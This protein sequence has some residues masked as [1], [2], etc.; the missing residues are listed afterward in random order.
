MKR[1][2]F[3]AALSLTCTAA[4]AELPSPLFCRTVEMCQAD[5][6]CAPMRHQPPFILSHTGGEGLMR[7]SARGAEAWA[8]VAPSAEVALANAPLGSLIALINAG[9][10]EEGEIAL[11]EHRLE[12]A[13]LSARY[14]RHMCETN[15]D[16]TS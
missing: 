15:E 3:T 8:V 10:T 1:L 7:R 11:H 12:P 4:Y 16:G 9:E 13:S 2:V 5:G 6:E 14:M